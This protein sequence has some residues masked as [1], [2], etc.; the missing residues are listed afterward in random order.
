MGYPLIR[1][2]A[3]LQQ[4]ADMVQGIRSE[5]DARANEALRRMALQAQIAHEQ[6]GTEH[7]TVATAGERQRQTQEAK[8][9]QRA[10]ETRT[11]V[12]QI[13]GPVA[14]AHS[15]GVDPLSP[16]M[17]QTFADSYARIADPD[18]RQQASQLFHQMQQDAIAAS[19][20]QAERA[21]G[22]LAHK[23]AEVGA[24]TVQQDAT[25][26]E[27]LRQETLRHL[28]AQTNLLNRQAAAVGQGQTA[29]SR[30]PTLRAALDTADRAFAAMQASRTVSHLTGQQ[31]AAA[32]PTGALLGRTIA[33]INL[34]GW[35]PG[36]NVGEA[37][38]QRNMTGPQRDYYNAMLVLSHT[39]P[40]LLRH[41]R[42]GTQ[43]IQMMTE[44][45]GQIPG[46]T[47]PATI[48]QKMEMI[49]GILHDFRQEV[50]SGGAGT[51]SDPNSPA[52]PTGPA[53]PTR[54]GP[55]APDLDR[56]FYNLP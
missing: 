7:E 36:Q 27:Q 55:A 22:E 45:L 37:I 43:M 54:P 53:T 23:R 12:A 35:R 21:T 29:I 17:S 42:V 13:M 2:P 47:D 3:P 1:Y 30:D 25:D 18:A 8:D 50:E 5:R 48:N 24:T 34:L 40:S 49:R 9:R 16:Q 33:G 20:G 32:I 56:R 51:A 15:Q 14:F 38:A 46:Q 52:T 19:Q 44:A 6:A 31:D 28:R 26:A 10:D 41:S 4:L 11:A 39:Y